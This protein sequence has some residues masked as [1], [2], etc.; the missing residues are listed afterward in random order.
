MGLIN[1]AFKS[2]WRRKWR[3]G[4]ALIAI[5]IAMAIMIAIPAGLNANQAAAVTARDNIQA[6]ISSMNNEI[7][8][9]SL[10]VEASYGS[11]GRTPGNNNFTRQ[12]YTNYAASSI[13]TFSTTDVSNISSLEGVVNIVEY[14]Q[15]TEGMPNMTSF[16]PGSFTRG[17][18]SF[19]RSQIN[20]D[21]VYTV[22]GIPTN[23]TID[24]I[25]P[26]I[27]SGRG[28]NPNEA[29]SA[30]ISQALATSWNIG[31]GDTKTIEGVT[32]TIVGISSS[33]G[34]AM[35]N[36][37]IYLDLA[38]AEEMY[39][40]EGKDTNLYVYTNSTSSAD[41]VSTE[42]QAMFSS[43]QVTTSTERIAALSS[44]QT[45]MSNSLSTTNAT[46]AQTQA[47]ADQETI[48]ALVAT[49]A[50]ILLIM[51]FS[52]RERTKEIGVMKTLG[53]S[54]K[55]VVSQFLLE[56]VSVTFIGCI[57]GV[58]V[59]VVAYPMISKI[60]L[61]TASSTAAR[62]GAFAIQT[63]AATVTA[64]PQL[65]MVLIAFVAVMAMGALGSIYPAWKASRVKPAEAL[66][67][68]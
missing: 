17:S 36:R 31:V 33:T 28:L 15:K 53:F 60:M 20:L 50:I 24:G 67:N 26:T 18:G 25:T 54:N 10:V 55:N 2:I 63:A 44:S 40:M 12:S 65:G 8:N 35:S 9:M 37:I 47:S 13:S 5:A 41:N 59:G 27:I 51:V 45:A 61:P 58:I 3:T 30:V 14:V 38:Q 29:G 39:S 52:V 48:L 46:L 68:E 42:M 43:A 32:L 7:Q 49:S 11:A 56:G 62:G 6:S 21:S 34:S 64:S 57:I 19:T 16:Q 66:R 22:W 1:R 23:A 4:V